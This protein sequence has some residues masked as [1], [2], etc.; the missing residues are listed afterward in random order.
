MRLKKESVLSLKEKNNNIGFP[1]FASKYLTY[2]MTDP[3][4]II[5]DDL[6]I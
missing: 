4:N 1:T 2:F 3:F 5:F 6:G